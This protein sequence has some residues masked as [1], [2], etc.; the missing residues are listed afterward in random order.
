MTSSQKIS[1]A[2]RNVG[3]GLIPFWFW[4]DRMESGETLRQLRE[5]AEK[6]ISDVVLHARFGL[7]PEQYLS[8][9]WFNLISLVLKK[10]KKLGVKVWLYDEYNWPSGSAAGKVQKE[11][12]EFEEHYLVLVTKN[13]YGP[14]D[15][16]EHLPHGSPVIVLMTDR[17]GENPQDVSK[18]IQGDTISLSVPEGSWTIN[19]FLARPCGPVMPYRIGGYLTDSMNAGATESFL[20]HTHQ[21]YAARYKPEFGKNIMGAFTDE[22][23]FYQYYGNADQRTLPWTA[24][25]S[26]EFLSRKGYRIEPHLLALWQDVGSDFWVHRCHYYDV[27]TRFSRTNYWGLIGKW[28]EKNKLFLV[29]HPSVATQGKVLQTSIQCSGNNMEILRQMSIPGMDRINRDPTFVTEK[30]T[31]SVAHLTGKPRASSETFGTFDWQLTLQ[32]MKEWTDRQFVRGI[33][34]LFLHAFYYSV[35]DFRRAECPPSLF[36]QN[37]FWPYFKKYADYAKR[38]ATKM[39]QG[40][41]VAPVAIYYPIVSAFGAT[42]A[43]DNQD[44]DPLNRSLQDL[45]TLLSEHQWDFDIVDDHLICEAKIVGNS[46]QIGGEKF[47]V[48]VL[49]SSPILPVSTLKKITAFLKAGG[50]VISA[51]I[52]PERVLDSGFAEN[53]SVISNFNK[54]F[55]GLDEFEKIPVCKIRGV[56]VGEALRS[57]LWVLDRLLEKDF[58]L[59]DHNPGIRCMHKRLP[60][61]DIYFVVNES[62]YLF[63]STVILQ[64]RHRP[65]LIDCESGTSFPLINNCKQIRAKNWRVKISIPPG[66]SRLLLCTDQKRNDYKT[67]DNALELKTIL[68][69]KDSWNVSIEGKEHKSVLRPW[70]ELGHPYF[71]GTAVYET[72]FNVSP[73]Q[74]GKR[75]FLDLGEVKEIA[76]LE[77]NDKPMGTA[78]W[79][80]FVLELTNEIKPGINHLK[81]EVTNTLA[82]KFYREERPS[83]LFGPVQLMI[84]DSTS[85]KARRIDTR[86]WY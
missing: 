67:I 30:I 18:N 56:K 19:Y 34:M 61:G 59:E 21:K 57:T 42:R 50:K 69:L 74:K 26:A 48:L 65:M 45:C 46:L 10:A 14:A 22:P 79:H 51:G 44:V 53:K 58:C 5:M 60:N 36:F 75:Y 80:P 33:N 16:H 20:K 47:F 64:T 73:F 66:G 17:S 68:F 31:S 43:G 27:L 29:G 71:S 85:K 28:C 82:N 3:F 1:P 52:T 12:P 84:N 4:N 41:H 77:L 24:N 86:F 23:G 37:L 25:F 7:N 6:G 15:F 72:D 9:E 55:S 38:L 49:P 39:S 54:Y 40:I 35:A 81:I 63:D 83:G 13:I 62:I 32:E 78:I 11:N 2:G 8:K 76:E 70:S